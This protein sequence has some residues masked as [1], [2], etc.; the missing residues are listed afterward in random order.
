[1]KNLKIFGTAACLSF[2]LHSASAQTQPSPGNTNPVPNTTTID[3]NPTH[4]NHENP[5]TRKTQPN[6]NSNMRG[7]DVTPL[8]DQQK[9]ASMRSADGKQPMNKKT[10][11]KSSGKKTVTKS[12]STA[13]KDNM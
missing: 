11:T 6:N 13:K 10:V 12:K 5:D 2:A 4:T 9:A 8:P 3:R 1:M 7:S